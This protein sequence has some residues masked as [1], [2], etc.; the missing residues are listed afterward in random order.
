MW[1]GHP[2]VFMNK[3]EELLNTSGDS[4]IIYFLE[5][6]LGYHENRKEK[7]KKSPFCPEEKLFPK[8][9]YNVYLKRKNLRIVQ[10]LKNQ[11]VIG[12]MRKRILFIVGC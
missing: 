1:H 10:K 4:D 7:T 12:L 2:D 3:L 5:I 11:Y 6:D 9:N 8:N